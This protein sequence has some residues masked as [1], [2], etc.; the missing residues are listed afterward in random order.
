MSVQII[1]E[2]RALATAA[3]ARA[4]QATALLTVALLKLGAHQEKGNLRVTA[5]DLNQVPKY[6]VKV[7]PKGKGANVELVK[8]EDN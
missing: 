1:E 7:T 3:E 5:N 2:Y 4:Q 8:Q 6:S